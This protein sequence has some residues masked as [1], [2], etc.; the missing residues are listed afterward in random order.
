MLENKYNKAG[1]YS[2]FIFLKYKNGSEKMYFYRGIALASD[3]NV[4]V[5]KTAKDAA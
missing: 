3:S 2:P 5:H 1:F 4:A